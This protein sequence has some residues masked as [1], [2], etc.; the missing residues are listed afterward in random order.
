MPREMDR[1]HIRELRRAHE[2]LRRANCRNFSASFGAQ[3]ISR[4]RVP[5]GLLVF[6]AIC[7]GMIV[8]GLQ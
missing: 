4:R 8:A 5:F 6:L 1:E 2:S 7:A 3:N